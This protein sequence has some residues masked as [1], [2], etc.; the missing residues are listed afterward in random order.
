[1]SNRSR[2][3]AAARRRGFGLLDTVGV[4]LV[5]GMLMSFSVMVLNRAFVVHNTALGYFQQ[6][7]RLQ[8]ASGRFR[9][10]A[11]AAIQCRAGNELHL[12]LQED[13]EVTYA[14]EGKTLVRLVHVD[15][16]ETARDSW[17]LPSEAEVVWTVD[18]SRQVPL[19]ICRLTFLDHALADQLVEWLARTELPRQSVEG[20]TSP[21]EA[22]DN[23]ADE[24][25][26][27]EQGDQR[28]DA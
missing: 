3:N 15:G 23:S 13:R 27:S 20:P 28:E 4:I 12:T 5:A 8:V 19:V 10:D 17:E 7:Q 25:S 26:E 14:A 9:K 16:R 21:P 1:M 6:T 11:H 24:T 18:R 2:K 22:G